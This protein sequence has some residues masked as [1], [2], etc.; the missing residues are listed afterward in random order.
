MEKKCKLILNNKEVRADY[1]DGDIEDTILKAF[2]S[3]DYEEKIA[4][5]LKNPSWPV[6][7]HL[8]D[9]RKNLLSWF[10]FNPQGALLEVG[11]GCGALTELFCSKLKEIVAVELTNRRASITA[12]RCKNFSNLTV[13]AGNIEDAKLSREFDYVTSVGVLEYAGKFINS[14]NPF[15]DFLKM[16]KTFLKPKGTLI[17]AIEN[18]FGL[19]YWS[20]VS[21]DHTGKFFDSMEGYPNDKGIQTFGK[22]EL[23]RL[24]KQAGFD[25][26]EFYYPLPDYKLPSEIFSDEYPP[27]LDHNIRAGLLPVRDHCRPR[28]YLFNERLVSDGIVIN[29]SFDFFANSYL[30]FAKGK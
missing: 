7:Y 15:E 4:K 5:L 8:A 30:V 24:L 19:K 9:Q 10:E 26:L 12:A 1:S 2:E 13:Y 28:T 17:L 3:E 21:E 29:N 18:K 11:S 22:Q 6:Y 23:T 27:T 20:G 16:L 25:D 14:D